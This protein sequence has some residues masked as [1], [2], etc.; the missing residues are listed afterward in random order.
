MP[1]FTRHFAFIRRRIFHFGVDC[2][3]I[4]AVPIEIP[5][6]LRFMQLQKG[7]RLG[8]TTSQSA[9]TGTASDD[10]S[11]LSSCECRL[12]H[13][14]VYGL[15]VADRTGFRIQL[16]E[17][18]RRSFVRDEN[19]RGGYPHE[20]PGQPQQHDQSDTRRS[21]RSAEEGKNNVS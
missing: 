9:E 10:I 6:T 17:A 5:Q 20:G 11:L 3:R 15:C 7:L 2:F 16:G 14:P 13:L 12:P 1:G 21:A 19:R 8:T 4:P 18:S